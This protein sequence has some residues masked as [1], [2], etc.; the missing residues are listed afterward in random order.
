MTLSVLDVV[1]SLRLLFVPGFLTRSTEGDT[2][3]Q[4]LVKIMRRLI[5]C[6]A[7]PR[8]NKGCAVC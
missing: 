1:V 6:L 7:T 2:D 5:W 8:T 3:T 4:R